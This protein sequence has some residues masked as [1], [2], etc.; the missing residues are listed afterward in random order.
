[1]ICAFVVVVV[2]VLSATAAASPRPLVLMHGL[3]AS[4]EAMSHVE[5]WAKQDVPGLHVANIEIGDGYYDSLLMNMNAQVE[6][7]ARAVRADARLAN[8]FNLVGHSQ[9]GLITRAYIER[10]N[11]PPVF[12]YV[13]LAGPHGG[14]YGVPVFNALDCP[15]SQA[16]CDF[17]NALFSDVLNNYDVLSKDI[18]EHLSFASYWHDPFAQQRF[19]AEN[20]FLADLNNA[21]AVKNATY[22]A[23][24]TSLNHVTLVYSLID[25]IVVPN[26]SPTF[27]FFDYVKGTDK[28]I[29]PMRQTPDYVG[30]WIGLQT[31][32][33]AGKLD[34][35]GVN[36]THADLPRLACKPFVYDRLI[37]PWII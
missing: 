17:A 32:D 6:Q 24:F 15:D 12:N 27:S 5:Q 33:R 21:R 30:D 11:S 1:M 22:K 34:V 2:V 10:F 36:C 37:R 19:L 28:A 31:I 25:N 20:I 18:Q 4:S 7:F 16:Q 29:L 8:G 3:L 35:W 26:V 23:H 14:Q 9:G 13:S